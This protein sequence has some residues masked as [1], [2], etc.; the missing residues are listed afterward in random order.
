MP[1]PAIADI[2]W[3]HHHHGWS[4]IVQHERCK[5]VNHRRSHDAHGDFYKEY[6]L[7]LQVSNSLNGGNIWQLIATSKDLSK[8]LIMG[9]I[10]ALR[11]WTYISILGIFLQDI[12]LDVSCVKIKMLSVP[13][14][15]LQ[16]IILRRIWSRQWSI[17]EI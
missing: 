3:H 13:C 9:F 1:R 2:S 4:I 10:Q 11:K 6:Y 5:D 15:T 8:A 17:R 16:V 14:S 12:S 7:T